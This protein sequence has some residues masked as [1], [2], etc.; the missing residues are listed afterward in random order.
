MAL[1][2]MRLKSVPPTTFGVFTFLLKNLSR[3]NSPQPRI[4]TTRGFLQKLDV[5]TDRRTDG[6]TDP[7]MDT[8]SYRD[9]WRI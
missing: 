1:N 3:T 4:S 6:P 7:R 2:D 9:A 8:P 5:P